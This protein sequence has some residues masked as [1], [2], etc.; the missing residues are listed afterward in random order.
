MPSS[1]VQT[2]CRQSYRDF[3]MDHI[4]ETNTTT[5]SVSNLTT[6]CCFRGTKTFEASELT[7]SSVAEPTSAA[8]QSSALSGHTLCKDP[9]LL[10]NPF[11]SSDT[12]SFASLVSELGKARSSTLSHPRDL[13]VATWAPDHSPVLKR[14]SGPAGNVQVVLTS[15]F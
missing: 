2:A 7:A 13:S 1:G 5:E 8:S 9:V 6:V 3:A 12:V 15:A 10:S 4:L 14:C 11:V